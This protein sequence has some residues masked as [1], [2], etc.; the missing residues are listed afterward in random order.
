M[1]PTEET[2]D[3]EMS[4]ATCFQADKQAEI[5]ARG[6]EINLCRS[7]PIKDLC[8][9]E[10]GVTEEGDGYGYRFLVQEAIKSNEIS[11]NIQGVTETYIDEGAIFFIDEFSQ[12]LDFIDETEIDFKEFAKVSSRLISR[13]LTFFSMVDDILQQGHNEY[14]HGVPF[15]DLI[16]LLQV[17]DSAATIGAQIE[18]QIANIC[19]E[20]GTKAPKKWIADFCGIITG[21]LPGSITLKKGQLMIYKKNEQLMDKLAKQDAMYVYM[22]ATATRELLSVSLDIPLENILQV[23]DLA[24]PTNNITITQIESLEQCTKNRSPKQRK[25]VETC[26]EYFTKKF[27]GNVGFIDWKCWAK[28]GD[29][30]HFVDGRG[31]NLFQ[32]KRAVVAFGTPNPNAN[33]IR[34]HYE[35]LTASVVDENDPS[36]R[37]FYVS[38]V[39]AEIEQE[40]GRL[41]AANRV[42]Q[43][44]DYFLFSTVNLTFLSHKGYQVK[45]LYGHKIDEELGFKKQVVGKKREL[46]IDRLCQLAAKEDLDSMSVREAAQKLDWQ[47]SAF[48]KLCQRQFGSWETVKEAIADMMKQ[49]GS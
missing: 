15:M 18:N 47:H 44:V 39:Q 26:R 3:W 9:K 41:R 29:L 27:D 13:G 40:V 46:I 4:M 37:N 23:E 22:D 24:P 14:P 17:H 49:Q 48:Y 45:R 11:A 35:V 34:A 2:G 20:K 19:H 21:N 32:N 36:F 5:Y 7:C 33:A 1:R 38:H 28:P 16:K 12:T 6:E 43:I 42:D 30:T 31:S 25:A 10:V 8:K